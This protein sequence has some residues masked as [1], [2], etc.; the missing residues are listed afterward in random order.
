MTQLNLFVLINVV[1]KTVLVFIKWPNLCSIDGSLRYDRTGLDKQMM[2][3]RVQSGFQVQMICLIYMMGNVTQ[4]TWCVTV[5]DSRVIAYNRQ[6]L[7]VR[8]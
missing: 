1:S 3:L 8:M 4:M 5:R 2:R 7:Y 6:S